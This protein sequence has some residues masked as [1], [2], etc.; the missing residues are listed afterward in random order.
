MANILILDD[1]VLIAPLIS[2][3]LER[4]GHRTRIAR[5]AVG[6]LGWMDLEDF[7]LVVLD[8]MMAGP[9]DGLDLCSA[10]RSDPRKAMSKILMISGVHDM[11]ENALRA[12]ADAFLPKPFDLMEIV[13]SVSGLLETRR[14]DWTTRRGYSIREMI[15]SYNA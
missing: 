4:Y 7:D 5:S 9:L 14:G 11:E 12:G 2:D 1:E 8:I 3:C 15:H 13:N 6:A 10:I